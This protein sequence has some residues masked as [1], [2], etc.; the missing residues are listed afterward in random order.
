M[1]AGVDEVGERENVPVNNRV[2][3]VDLEEVDV[4]GSVTEGEYT[5]VRDIVFWEVRLADHDEDFVEERL[6]TERDNVL[7]SD[8]L[9][10]DAVF[11]VEE[12]VIDAA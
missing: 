3:L 7:A 2:V 11:I 5:K 1:V 10:S 4:N 8:E 9:D 12:D 6:F